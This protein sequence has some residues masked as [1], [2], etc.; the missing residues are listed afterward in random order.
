M[1]LTLPNSTQYDEYLCILGS[2]N[3]LRIRLYLSELKHNANSL[4][5]SNNRTGFIPDDLRMVNWQSKR[6]EWFRN[7]YGLADNDTHIEWYA[8]VLSVVFTNNNKTLANLNVNSNRGNN[9]L[10]VIKKLANVNQGSIEELYSLLL[11]KLLASITGPNGE[12]LQNRSNWNQATDF[13]FKT[14]DQI[15]ETYL[16]GDERQVSD[17]NDYLVKISNGFAVL[18]SIIRYMNNQGTTL[19]DILHQQVAMN[20]PRFLGLGPNPTVRQTSISA[21]R[22][23][24]SISNFGVKPNALISWNQVTNGNIA[25]VN[26]ST[27]ANHNQDIN[28]SWTAFINELHGAYPNNTVYNPNNAVHVGVKTIV[29]SLMIKLDVLLNDTKFGYN[30]DKFMI[31]SFL[32]SSVN[33]AV[34]PVTP[35]TVDFSDVQDDNTSKQKYI[36]KAADGYLYEVKPD[37]SLE[38]VEGNSSAVQNLKESDKCY[39]TGL[40]PSN[41]KACYEYLEECIKG[42]DLTQCKTYLQDPNFWQNAPKEVEKMQP[43]IAYQTLKSFE[44]GRVSKK[45]NNRKIDRVQTWNEW[46]DS[47]K[48][49]LAPNELQNIAQ[50]VKLQ[51]YLSLIVKKVNDN[52]AILNK[53]YIADK[54]PA[55]SL[56]DPS[57]VLGKMGL[58]YSAV[59]SDGKDVTNSSVLQLKQALNRSTTNLG[60]VLGLAPSGFGPNSIVLQVGGSSYSENYL[61]DNL[62]QQHSIILNMYNNLKNRLNKMNKNVDPQSDLTIAK[63]IEELKLRERKLHKIILMTERYAEL[64]TVHGQQDPSSALTLPHLEKFVEQRNN[65]FK[66]VQTKQNNLISIIQA[67]SENVQNLVNNYKP[68]K[69]LQVTPLGNY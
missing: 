28:N 52:P 66:K 40:E 21:L 7:K 59:R 53:D 1:S 38:L 39:G 26:A 43:I 25:V 54:N 4:R 13:R 19:S 22:T 34:L 6:S 29:D 45:I 17:Y 8:F 37:G 10:Q 50:N 36:R 62:T 16:I 46:L 48:S 68:Q 64:L 11:R 65:Y 12:I 2:S 20:A 14:G 9:L 49:K 27:H 24:F 3:D 60:M 33:N 57:S 23:F 15:L 44:F 32:M 35:L 67:I 51:E 61:N 41:G 42:G 47:I 5:T 69:P 56:M 58:N 31:N 30:Y 63:L 18:P 55:A